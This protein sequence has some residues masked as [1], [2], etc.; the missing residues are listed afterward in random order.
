[1]SVMIGLVLTKI[2]KGQSRAATI[3]FSEKAIIEEIDGCLYFSFQLAELRKTPLLKSRV[4]CNVFRHDEV[5]AGGVPAGSLTS[6]QEKNVRTWEGPVS[7]TIDCMEQEWRQVSQRWRRLEM[8]RERKL[9][10]AMGSPRVSGGG[11][12]RSRRRHTAEQ[13]SLLLRGQSSSSK[14][15]VIPSSSSNE[16]GIKSRYRRGTVGYSSFFPRGGDGGGGEELLLARGRSSPVLLGT[17]GAVVGTR[18]EMLGAEGGVFSLVIEE[19]EAELP[20]TWTTVGNSFTGMKRLASPVGEQLTLGR[21]PG[22]DTIGSSALFTGGPQKPSMRGTVDGLFSELGEEERTKIDDLPQ[23]V[24]RPSG[25]SAGGRGATLQEEAVAAISS[26]E[27]HREEGDSKMLFP[28]IRGASPLARHKEPVDLDATPA[29]AGDAVA[30]RGPDEGGPVRLTEANLSR[31]DDLVSA[32]ESRW[33]RTPY[34]QADGD[35]VIVQFPDATPHRIRKSVLARV[36]DRFLDPVLRSR[37]RS[38]DLQEEENE[39]WRGRSRFSMGSAGA[40]QPG[41]TRRPRRSSSS[42]LSPSREQPRDLEAGWPARTLTENHDSS[43]RGGP[44]RGGPPSRRRRSVEFDLRIEDNEPEPPEFFVPS[45]STGCGSPRAGTTSRTPRHANQQHL[46]SSNQVVPKSADKASFFFQQHRMRLQTPNDRRPLPL[47]LEIPSKVMHRIDAWSPLVPKGYHEVVARL[48]DVFYS[49]S[50]QLW[51]EVLTVGAGSAGEPPAGVLETT[52]AGAE[53]GAVSPE[54]VFASYPTDVVPRGNSLPQMLSQI[55]EHKVASN[56]PG[57]GQLFSATAAGRMA[58]ASSSCPA[59]KS[60]AGFSIALPPRAVSAPGLSTPTSSSTAVGGPL[61]PLGAGSSGFPSAVLSSPSW[62]ASPTP[63]RNLLPSKDSSAETIIS[64]G[65]IIGPAGTTTTLRRLLTKSDQELSG[66]E[67]GS[68]LRDVDAEMGQRCSRTCNVCGQ[69]FLTD[70]ELFLHCQQLASPAD[71]DEALHRFRLKKPQFATHGGL[72][73]AV[74]HRLR[75]DPFQPQ[76]LKEVVRNFLSQNYVE[77]VVIVEG[78]EPITT[79]PIQARYSYTSE[80]VNFDSTFVPCVSTRSHNLVVDY[81][82]FQDLESASSDTE[83]YNSEEDEG[84]FEFVGDEF[85]DHFRREGSAVVLVGS[86]REGGEGG[87]GDSLGSG[88]VDESALVIEESRGTAEAEGIMIVGGP[89]KRTDSDVV[90]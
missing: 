82:Q 87:A 32:S 81:W 10:S 20:P 90:K 49:C 64:S 71:H 76:I 67:F 21:D 31:L 40:S 30:A 70:S 48:E 53:S 85:E 5:G 88:A 23:Q 38:L 52:P 55:D 15:G 83:L 80:D 27:P 8:R 86:L 39:I 46:A 16:G 75:H 3:I 62:S 7:Q 89:P 56:S 65:G 79:H 11:E 37:G 34:I 36:M 84:E 57:G 72:A 78:I 50:G 17:G 18:R 13:N 44:P 29:P 28:P 68:S 1:M 9:A 60:T 19:E 41:E 42:C 25:T 45:S 24:S 63:H 51:E 69:S 26:S 77:I 66:N 35:H 33:Q 73:L 74:R 22:R 59:S 14:E 54:A 6:T 61:A 2:S 58:T 4:Q 43:L 47:D 12:R